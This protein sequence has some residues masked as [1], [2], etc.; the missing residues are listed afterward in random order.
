MQ[1]YESKDRDNLSAADNQQ[2]RPGVDPESSTTIC[3]A[4]R[5]KMRERE[6]YEWDESKQRW[7][8]IVRD[9]IA[10]CCDCQTWKTLDA[11][12]SVYGKPYQYC[13]ACQR[14]HKAMSRYGVDRE[15]AI[16]LYSIWK[17]E[18][19]GCEIEKQSHQHIHHVNGQV[20]GL[21][22]LRCNHTLRDESPEHVARLR[23]CVRFIETRMKIESD[24]HGDMQR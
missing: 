4:P 14:L 23:S 2:E 6:G 12:A 24:L 5:R 22:C 21:V 16:R 10:H 17:C 18:C 3:A 1:Q 15:E 11:F 13:K 20:I 19:C 9:G 8:R 7:V